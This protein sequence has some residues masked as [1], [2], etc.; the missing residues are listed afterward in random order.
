MTKSVPPQEVTALGLPDDP[1]SDCIFF[2]EN[3]LS[4]QHLIAPK[5]P[6]LMRSL[7]ARLRRFLEIVKRNNRGNAMRYAIQNTT[8]TMRKIEQLYFS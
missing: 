4:L 5:H 7:F 1:R 3:M 8:I 2:A 6:L